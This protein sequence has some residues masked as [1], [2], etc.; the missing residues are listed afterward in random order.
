FRYSKTLTIGVLIMVLCLIPS[1]EFS[2][3]KMPITYTD[4][5]LHFCMF[6]AFSA[7]LY[8]DITK[9][10]TGYKLLSVIMIAI[11]ISFGLAALTE[12]LQYLI[13]PLNRSGS[14]SDLLSDL[15]GNIGGVILSVL[16]RRRSSV[17]P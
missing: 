17:V 7:A 15:L 2:K 11:I 3:I 12:M 9:K 16:I 1:S 4:L 5:I 10:R 6:F 13:I 8:L 14:A